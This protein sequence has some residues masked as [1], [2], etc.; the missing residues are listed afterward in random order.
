MGF[1]VGRRQAKEDGGKDWKGKGG[2]SA[3]PGGRASV[4]KPR[5]GFD[6]ARE[7]THIPRGDIGV[8]RALGSLAPVDSRPVVAE[9]PPQ[10]RG[11]LDYSPNVRRTFLLSS[12]A[13][14]RNSPDFCWPRTC[15]GPPAARARVYVAVQTRL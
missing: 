6:R 12:P 8:K 15:S 14:D 4:S 3:S 1:E 9:R 11:R 5:S 13:I 2:A 7:E 10:S